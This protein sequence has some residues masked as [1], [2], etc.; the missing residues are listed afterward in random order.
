M[1]SYPAASCPVS[2]SAD[3]DGLPAGVLVAVR[4]CDLVSPLKSGAPLGEAD[5]SAMAVAGTRRIG[6]GEAVVGPGHA[7][8]PGRVRDGRHR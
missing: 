1:H 6:T 7:E 2:V 4:A 8:E 5:R 3:E